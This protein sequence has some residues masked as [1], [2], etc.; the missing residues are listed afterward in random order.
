MGQRAPIVV[1]SD[2]DIRTH[3]PPSVYSCKARTNIEFMDGCIYQVTL[4]RELS[5]VYEQLQEETIRLPINC[6]MEVR[7]LEMK[8]R[9][10]NVC[11]NR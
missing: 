10:R 5:D 3:T 11:P 4:V 1:T 6:A 2:L 8:V 9:H 7:G